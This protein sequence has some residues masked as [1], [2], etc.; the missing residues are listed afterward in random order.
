MKHLLRRLLAAFLLPIL[1]A[2]A[3]VTGQSTA[4]AQQE[5]TLRVVSTLPVNVLDVASTARALQVYGVSVM[6]YDRLLTFETVDAGDGFKA[7]DMGKPKGELA[8]SWSVSEDRKSI[9]IR[10]KEA[11]FHDGTPV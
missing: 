9:T 4:S 5:G 11:T 8:E 10:L 1:A 7:S 2:L 3:V 6:I